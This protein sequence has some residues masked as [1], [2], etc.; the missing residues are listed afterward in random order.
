MSKTHRKEPTTE[1]I[2]SKRQYNRT[3][4]NRVRTVLASTFDNDTTDDISS[5]STMANSLHNEE[6]DL[7]SYRL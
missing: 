7:G 6:L 3:K 1:K 5:F 4:R 2:N